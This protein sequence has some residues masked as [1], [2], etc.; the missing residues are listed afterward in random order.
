MHL[1]AH[2]AGS[3]IA[4]RLIR[5][6]AWSVFGTATSRILV[7]MAMIILARI[8]GQTKFGEFG[9]IQSTMIVSGMM[10]GFGLG[11]TATRFV[12]Q[13]RKTDPYR[14]G[15]T[16]A[17]VSSSS[18][19]L[20][21]IVG[22]SI[23][24]SSEQIA[25]VVLSAPHLQTAV[26]LGVSLMV[27]MT[28]RGI[29]SAIL[30]GMERFDVIAKLNL[31]EGLLSLVGVVPLAILFGTEGGLLGLAFAL[32]ATWLLGRYALLRVLSSHN[33]PVIHKGSWK[34]RGILTSYSLPNFLANSLVSP[35]VWYCM[36]LVAKRP[37]GYDDLALYHAAYQWHGPMMFIPLML[38]A[39]S[40]PVLV[41]L[42]ESASI[43]RF[44]K[45]YLWNSGILLI[46]S[47]PPV[48]IVGTL[49]P[50]I[51]TLYGESFRN[52]WLILV[53]LVAAAPINALARM[54]TTALF[55]MHRA[56]SVFLLNLAW[57]TI[58]IALATMLIPQMGALGLASAF[59]SAYV[60]LLLF[61]TTLLFWHLHQ[62][63]K[64]S[65]LPA[66]NL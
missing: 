45:V 29:Q 49:S 8:L 25:R 55:G 46:I 11:S 24:L 57:A 36:T 50:W 61:T 59:L 1:Y 41:Q 51:M 6:T 66:D 26:M 43:Q 39:V 13:H 48:L 14:A 22:L 53:L 21:T 5:G 52:G 10:A 18:W 16:I 3:D 15:R 44:R 17:L 9:M 42:W 34:E 64:I 54:G 63:T 27:A 31:L 56:W 62:S 60:V 19:I 20:L 58:L 37:D 12:A 32:F 23:T 7:L 35:V 47:A 30:A 4:K 33:V 28:I 65:H 40:M 38:N 2:L